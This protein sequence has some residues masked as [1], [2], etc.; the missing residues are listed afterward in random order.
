MAG[1]VIKFNS[2][3]EIMPYLREWKHRLFLDEWIICVGFHSLDEY[4]DEN[5]HVEF[6]IMNKTATITL[7]DS[8]HMQDDERIMRNCHELILV[9][10]L[11]H[12]KIGFLDAPSTAEGRLW[13]VHEHQLI[14]EMS[15]SLIMAKYNIGLDWFVTGLD[16]TIGEHHSE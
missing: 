13:R 8:D 1:P 6:S 14:Y 16:N 12:L 7:L 15:K 10:E 2:T 5:G 4:P 11:L 3:A 9:H